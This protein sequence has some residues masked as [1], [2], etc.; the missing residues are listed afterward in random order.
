M[1]M[2]PILTF[3]ISLF[4]LA[5]TVTGASQE[6]ATPKD[7]T[8]YKQ[9]YGLR[10]GTDIGKLI[11]TAV[12]KNYSGF[13]IIGDFR[14][15]KK[16]YIAG[17]LG[18]E[19]RTISDN[20]LNATSQGSFLKAGVDYNMYQNWLDMDNL[21]FVGFRV[22]GSSFN[23]TLNA[24]SIYNVNNSYWDNE[25]I[26]DNPQEFSGL[27]ALWLELVFGIKAELVKNLYMGLNVQLK[28]LITE[29]SPDDFENLWIPGFNKTFDSGPLG[30]GFGY[31]LSYRIPVFK[32]DKVVYEE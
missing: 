27:N 25:V 3:C 19:E 28:G 12:D 2:R 26:V 6:E 18:I 17:E 16:L 31:T 23:Q 4:W 20:A 14:I 22:G 5:G 15:T 29:K 1:K 30:W 13:E 7:S 32:K 11:R 9:K 8:I 10:L 24:Y 21:I